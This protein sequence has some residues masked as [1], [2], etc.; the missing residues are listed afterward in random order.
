MIGRTEDL[1]AILPITFHP[2]AGARLSIEVV[3][4]TGFTGDVTL[5]P[6]AVAAMGLAFLYNQAVTLAD[7]SDI[8]IGVYQ[9]QIVWAGGEKLVLVFATGKRPLIG[10]GLLAG[11]ELLV[12]F[13]ERGL[14]T[15]EAL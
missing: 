4:D 12:Q 3:I 1:H 8:T 10:T 15:V 9:A 11:C 6:A 14:V 2:P 13:A 5:P 7:D